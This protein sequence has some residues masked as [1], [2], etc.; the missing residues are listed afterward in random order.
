MDA[1]KRRTNLNAA[2]RPKKIIVPYMS[3]TFY[4]SRVVLQVASFL[5]VCGLPFAQ[6][7]VLFWI[8]T[9]KY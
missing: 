9:Y 3:W 6:C 4:V 7:N 2:K 5:Q 1:A 8:P